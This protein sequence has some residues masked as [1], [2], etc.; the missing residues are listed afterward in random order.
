MDR[1]A[2]RLPVDCVD[3][4]LR[5]AI[6]L[7]DSPCFC[8]AGL[9]LT[10]STSHTASP[11][12][13][14]AEPDTWRVA[15]LGL[16]STIV[17]AGLSY[18]FQIV[19]GRLMTTQSYSEMLAMLSLYMIST[20]PMAPIFLLV[21][22][23][24]VD[25]RLRRAD[26]D[27]RAL[28]MTLARYIALVSLVLVALVF[29]F[30][31][32]TARWLSISDPRAT[33]LFAASVAVSALYLLV[34]SI[35]LGREEWVMANTLP[36]LLGI[37]RI[38]LSVIFVR[39]GFEVGG[40]FLA[41][42]GSAILCLGLGARVALRGL[43][44]GGVYRA[45]HLTEVGMAIAVNLAFWFLVQVDTIYVNKQIP[46]VALHGYAAA[47]ALGKMLVYIPVAVGNVLFPLLTAARTPAAGRAMLLR[48]LLIAVVLDA[49]GFAIIAVS[50]E[51][52]L[53][54]TLGRAYV[55]AAPLLLPVAAVLA[56]FAVASIFM[57][58][59]LARH[60]RAITAL[61]AGAAVLAAVMLIAL[62][63]ALH[64]LFAVLLTGAAIAI[65]GGAI[66]TV[67]ARR[68]SHPAIASESVR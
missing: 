9:P 58:E 59:A 56:P 55:G 11:A 21:T 1:P 44:R 32:P 31:E 61:F 14:R 28:L 3:A 19:A 38:V 15:A 62:Q 43:P 54:L 17:A 51:R 23:R 53:V 39:P 57:Y 24:V 33:P 34:L 22:R 10:P 36:V 20:L 27:V 8:H 30:R 6:R 16:A 29:I 4:R 5:L 26:G 45:L 68:D 7:P 42:T 12:R 65:T 64:T 40:T 2:K 63:P 48:M 52:L 37:G 13:G 18:V 66:R 46:D 47:S 35:L 67:M 41:I 25:A 60:D 49:I 50:P